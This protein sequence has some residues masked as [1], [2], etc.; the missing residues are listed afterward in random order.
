VEMTPA[1]STVERIQQQVMFVGN[2][3]KLAALEG[4]LDKGGG[5][6]ALVFARTKHGADRLGKQMTRLGFEVGVLHGNKSQKQ[7]ENTM[8]GFRN[9]R[10]QVLVAT[11]IAARGI[12]IDG[13]SHVINFDVPDVAETYVHRIGRTAR[14]GAEG[15][16][17][18]LCNAEEK[19]SLRSIERLTGTALSIIEMNGISD[20]RAEEDVAARALRPNR[21]MPPRRKPRKDQRPQHRSA[22]HR[23]YARREAS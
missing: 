21:G 11:D 15:L 20:I 10:T 4:L 22:P 14:A 3:G 7:R 23:P 6:R 17:I 12:D 9:G 18:T 13:I 5:S 16:A 19:P 8:E 2:A 1:A